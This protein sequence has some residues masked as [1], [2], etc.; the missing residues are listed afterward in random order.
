MNSISIAMFVLT[1]R[2]QQAERGHAILLRKGVFV[3]AFVYIV[4]NQIV[5][6]L[7]DVAKLRENYDSVKC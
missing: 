3:Q 1:W 4:S 7:E 5:N 2:V 6:K